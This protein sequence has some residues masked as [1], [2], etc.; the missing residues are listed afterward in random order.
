MKNQNFY[1]KKFSIINDSE[2]ANISTIPPLVRRKLSQL[3]KIAISTMLEIGNCELKEIVFA[4][5]VGEIS[6]LDNIIE[7]YT[8]L[9]EVSPAQ[10]SA[11]VH[12]YLVGFFTNLKK[13]NIPYSAISSGEH[14]LS[15]GLVKSVL[16]LNTEV[17]FTYVDDVAVSCLIS[18]ESG[19]IKCEF[20]K[21]NCEYAKD[22]FQEF[23]SFLIGETRVFRTVFG[24]FVRL[25]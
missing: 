14:S 17:L 8:E 21:K 16:S 20:V 5:K 18:K 4:S 9:N 10:F 11:S 19:D 25:D 1:I 2:D 13:L 3:D 6:R 7:Q 12:N 24:E 15:A 22:E 23:K